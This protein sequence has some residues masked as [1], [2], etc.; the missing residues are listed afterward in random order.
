[1]RRRL[2]TILPASLLLLIAVA[3]LLTGEAMSSKGTASGARPISA[4]DFSREKF[5]RSTRID[6]RWFPLRPG[7]QFFY[8][9]ATT[10]EGKRVPHRTV[11]TVTDLAKTVAGVRVLVIWDRDYSQGRLVEGELAF[12]AQDNDGNVWHLGQYPEEYENGKFVGAPAFIAGVKGG[13]A[14]IEM[15][16]EP[17]LGAPSY[18]KGYAPAPI[19][20]T[21]RA[22][23]YKTGV[24]NCVPAGCFKDVLVTDEF[25]PEQPGKHQL[26]YYAPGVGNIRVGW[27]GEKETDKEVLVLTKIL[28]LDP[29]ALAN[30]RAEVLKFDKRAYKGRPDVYG[31]TSPAQRLR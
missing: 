4:N 3:A 6:N 2:F 1:M 28:H 31:H 30:V 10:E 26:K 19:N 5:D 21:D 25:N 15:K 27:M 20:W 29:K 13:R 23:T 24:R 12:F 18:S 14:G 7:M 11:F 17:R 8:Q 22:R 9:G 16:A